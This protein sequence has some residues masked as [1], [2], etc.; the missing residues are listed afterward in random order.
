MTIPINDT[1]ESELSAYDGPEKPKMVN[2][3]T[4]STRDFSK[5]QKISW[6]KGE[7][8]FLDI[9]SKDKCQ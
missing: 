9:V 4:N 5:M 8:L 6:V 2:T 3:E 7:E 1:Y